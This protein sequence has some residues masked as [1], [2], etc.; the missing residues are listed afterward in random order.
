MAIADKLVLQ[1]QRHLKWRAFDKLELVADDPLRRVVLRVFAVGDGRHRHADHRPSLAVA[2]GS[3]LH[4]VHLCDLHRR[5]GRYP[6]QRSSVSDR[7]LRGDARHAAADRRD[8]HSHRR[9]RR[10]VLPD[11]VRLYQ[12]SP[13]LRQFP[14]AVGHADR[15]ALCRDPVVRRADR[16]VHHRATRQRHPQR[17]RPSRAA[18]RGSGD[19]PPSTPTPDRGRG[20][21]RTR[22]PRL[23]DVLLPVLRLSRRARAVFAA[24]GRVRRRAC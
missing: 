11:L 16:A 12:L 23:D 6:P 2:A 14:P 9:A 21:E 15:L 8:H 18:G 3:H 5:R 10:G 1:R 22:H 4:A 7:D 24:G 17:I 13:R 19:I 20:R